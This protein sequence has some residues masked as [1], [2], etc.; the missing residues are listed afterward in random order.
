M[1]STLDAYQIYTLCSLATYLSASASAYCPSK[2]KIK[3]PGISGLNFS[4][5]M[6]NMQLDFS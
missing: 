4:S 2:L 1:I 6:N 5:R 3:C